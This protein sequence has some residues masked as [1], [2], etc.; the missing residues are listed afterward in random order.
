MDTTL[1]DGEQTPNVSYTPSE[2]F[3]IAQLLLREVKVDRIEIASALVSTGEAQAVRRIT[4]WARKAGLLQRVEIL[5]Y[6]DGKRSVDWIVENGG[7]ALNVLTKG[8]RLHCEQQLRLS[9]ERHFKDITET[10][11]Y[12]R[13]RRKRWHGSW[14]RCC[15]KTLPRATETSRNSWPISKSLK[16]HSKPPSP[17]RGMK[18]RSH[19]LRCCRLTT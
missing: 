5:G 18:N 17:E 6:V 1:R 9:P 2:K 15:A 11:R 19:P 16:R 12:A 8:S 14:R 10:I 13:R 7:G 4:S 3:Q